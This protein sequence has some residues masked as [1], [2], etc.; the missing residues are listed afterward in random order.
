ML[1]VH[2]AGLTL[3]H[4]IS[5]AASLAATLGCLAPWQLTIW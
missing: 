4:Y 1:A 2:A 3:Q 5:P